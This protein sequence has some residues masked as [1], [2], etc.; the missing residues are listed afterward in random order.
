M[1]LALA[2]PVAAGLS[3]LSVYV[4]VAVSRDVRGLYLSMLDAIVNARAA[5]IGRWAQGHLKTVRMNA[6]S[7]E[8]R[9]LDLALIEPFLVRRKSSLD[10]DQVDESFITAGGVFHNSRG[11]SGNISDREYY[12][13]I[14][15][16]RAEYFVSDGFLSRDTGLPVV[17]FAAATKDAKGSVVALA[18]TA[19]SLDTLSQIASSIRVGSGYGFIVDGGGIV[20]AHPRRELVMKP[21]QSETARTQ[22]QVSAPIPYTKWSMFVSV[23]LA[24]VD[25]TAVQIIGLLAIATAAI[26]AFLIAA[27]L[28]AAK[29]ITGP[30]S[31]LSSGTARV[32]AGD[33][34]GGLASLASGEARPD[35]V[36]DLSRAFAAMAQRLGETLRGYD[37]V[38]KV[39][40]ERNAELEAAEASL[41]KLNAN[42]E[43]R[44]KERTASL[45]GTLR[46]LKLAQEGVEMSAK[47]ALLGRLTASIAHDLNTPLGAIRSSAGLALEKMDGLFAEALAAFIDLDGEE[48]EA[49]FAILARGCVAARRLDA[50]ED[51]KIKRAL[52]DEFEARGIPDADA[53]ADYVVSMD[54]R[55]LADRIEIL[56]LAGKGRL[57]EICAQLSEI[58]RSEAIVLEAANKAASTV[59]ALANYS[60]IENLERMG[61]VRLVEEINSLITLYYSKLKRSVS[62]EKRF[63]ADDPVAGHRDELNSV[64]M[65]LMNNALQAMDYKGV[66]EIETRREGEEIV[67][68]F[69]DSGPGIPKKNK[70]KIFTPFFT[71]KVQGEGTGL[72]LDICRRIVE[73]HGGSIG[74]ETR[75]GRTTFWVRLAVFDAAKGMKNDESE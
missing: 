19:V 8:F 65:N 10:P 3:S 26:L 13:A 62:L 48:R 69:T 47:M 23:P 60:R 64:W 71:T 66:L 14:I 4:G 74:F 32:A 61:K 53:L 72:G 29:R 63:L 7:A 75:P 73:R 5:E 1:I 27:I 51:R 15:R 37:S 6:A 16:G 25:K 45:E 31:A 28:Y 12:R 43:D 21:F 39:L 42:L 30:I 22:V 41:K 67:V 40:A 34:N 35:E 68:S 58:V 18:N 36:G 38:N 70:A 9:S 46:D 44:V 20:I 11:R 56:V 57:I 17:V 55:D 50:I 59:A 49:V 33:L 52:A 24:Q 2:L 54:A